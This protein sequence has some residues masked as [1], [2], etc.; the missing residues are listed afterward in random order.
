M[1][2]LLL[3]PYTFVVLNWAPLAGLYYFLRRGA[4]KDIWLHYKLTVDASRER[5]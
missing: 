4:G 5:P 3:V 2:K 1:K